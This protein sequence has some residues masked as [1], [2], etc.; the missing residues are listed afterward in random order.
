MSA[1]REP[2][3]SRPLKRMRPRVGVRKWV[4][5]LKQVVFPAPLGPMSPWIVPRRT[6]RFTPFTATNPW[7]SLVRPSVSRMTSSAISG[8]ATRRRIEA[9]LALLAP[10]PVSFVHLPRSHARV[11]RAQHLFEGRARI[12]MKR[13]VEQPLRVGGRGG[14]GGAR[15]L[16]DRRERALEVGRGAHAVDEADRPRLGR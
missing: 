11:L 16:D 2:V 5:R 8:R 13:R 10:R 15:L 9:C 6:C 7:N 12:A 4:N 1:G 3:I 14:R